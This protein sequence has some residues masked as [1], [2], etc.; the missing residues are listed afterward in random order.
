M[1]HGTIKHHA[2]NGAQESGAMMPEPKMP[3]GVLL[4][5]L[6]KQTST[7]VMPN[8]WPWIPNEIASNKKAA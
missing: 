2:M 8:R 5:D 6:S 7:L 1:E 4:V 3:H